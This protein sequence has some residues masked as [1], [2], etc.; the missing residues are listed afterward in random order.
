MTSQT[1]LDLSTM[2]LKEGWDMN[3][4]ENEVKSTMEDYYGKKYDLGEV[5]KAIGDITDYRLNTKEINV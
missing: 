3:Y 5:K 2:L 1:I 4:D